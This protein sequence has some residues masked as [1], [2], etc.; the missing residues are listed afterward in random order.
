MPR[1][2]GACERCLEPPVDC[3][4]TV[5][6]RLR[7]VSS[8]RALRTKPERRRTSR[9]SKRESHTSNLQ[10]TGRSRLS[11]RGVPSI[12]S[13]MWRSALLREEPVGWSNQSQV[14]GREVLF[15]AKEG[16]QC[17]IGLRWLGSVLS[18]MGY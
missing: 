14:S 3:S 12:R 18:D 2:L 8:V 1:Q 17:G 7:I 11:P 10:A 5:F 16:D 4:L 15:V 6:T 13:A 9:W